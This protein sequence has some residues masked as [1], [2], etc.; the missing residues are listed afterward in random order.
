[1]FIVIQKNTD[2]YS[3]F[4]VHIVVWVVLVWDNDEMKCNLV[5]EVFKMYS[6]MKILVIWN[7]HEYGVLMNGNVKNVEN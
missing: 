6:E 2:F 3:E 4:Y 5:F 1:M 7:N